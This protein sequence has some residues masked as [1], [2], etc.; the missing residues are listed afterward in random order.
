[1]RNGQQAVE[2]FVSERPD[3][4][5]LDVAMTDG[6]GFDTAAEIRAICDGVE[7]WTPIVLMGATPTDAD[8]V[9]SID[10]G[11]DDYLEKP[12]RPMVLRAK[13]SAM[14]RIGRMRQRLDTANRAL[15][16]LSM[17]DGLTGIANRRCFESRLQE[18]W[19]R[20]GR[21]GGPL[22]LVL[23]DIDRFKDFNDRYG[24]VAGDDALRRVAR[25]LEST[26]TRAADLVARYGGEEFAV[27][28]P[29]TGLDDAAILAESVRRNVAELGIT[30]AGSGV[31]PHLT[32]SLGVS[33]ALAWPSLRVPAQLAD[34]AD[35]MLYRSKQAGR[36]RV[37]VATDVLEGTR[38]QRDLAHLL[39]S[40]A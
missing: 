28:L 5:L 17:Q 16:R 38:E 34:T 7:D 30:H 35:R 11:A 32:V 21:T 9:R 1:V 25:C 15:H 2:R 12:V 3:L 24:H 36:N 6:D 23:C 31:A 20:A 22:A 27:L 29:E 33:A 4:V 26:V 40:G 13:L 37:S 8:L 10:A 39:G 18:E 14:Q 19:Q